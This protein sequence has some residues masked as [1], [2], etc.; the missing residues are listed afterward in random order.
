MHACV[1]SC[2][3]NLLTVQPVFTYYDA[4]LIL[5][6]PPSCDFSLVF[7]IF[8]GLFFYFFRHRTF[9][10]CI[11]NKCLSFVVVFNVN[12]HEKKGV[13]ETKMCAVCPNSLQ[14]SWS[15]CNILSKIK[16]PQ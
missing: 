14:R 4:S 12:T 15:I 7:P 6:Y 1:S 13:K 11:L 16:S 3:V 10:V 5:I 9:S 8:L 2:A